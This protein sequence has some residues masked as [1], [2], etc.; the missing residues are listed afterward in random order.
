MPEYL[1]NF[2]LYP[3]SPVEIRQDGLFSEL[4]NSY[5][6]QG[7]WHS[8]ANEYEGALVGIREDGIVFVFTESNAARIR[9]AWATPLVVANYPKTTLILTLTPIV[10]SP[11][12]E[13]KA[14]EIAYLV[15]LESAGCL[16]DSQQ[17]AY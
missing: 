17:P 8:I 12:P 6:V 7:S 16:P 5:L 10:E 2:S 4:F 3:N 15:S 1:M 11:K 14:S 13:K 9:L